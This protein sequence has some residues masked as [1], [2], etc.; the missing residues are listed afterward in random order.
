MDL[1]RIRIIAFG[2]FE[3]QMLDRIQKNIALIFDVDVV[4]EQNLMDLSEHYD[5]ER[6]QYNANSLLALVNS[7]HTNQYLRT[8]GLFRVDIFIPILTF[9]F[10]QATFEGTCGIGSL[11]RLRNEKYGLPRNDELLY[12]RFRKVIIHELGHTFGL[13]HCQTPS[14]VMRSATYVEDIDQ[15]KHRF[16]THYEENQRHFLN[17]TNF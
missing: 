14:C 1:K 11:Y 7:L 15:K 8:I 13:I 16:C 6:L 10:G 5:P 9:I 3:Q 17:K 12:E 4:I 2:Q